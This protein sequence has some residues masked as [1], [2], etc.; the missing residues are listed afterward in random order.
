MQHTSLLNLDNTVDG[1]A[2]IAI[3][4]AILRKVYGSFDITQTCGKKTAKDLAGMLKNAGVSP[5]SIIL[6]WHLG[7]TDVDLVRD[8]LKSV[9]YFDI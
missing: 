5:K 4:M 2:K 8:F 3:S 7:W 6:V 9:G 1:P